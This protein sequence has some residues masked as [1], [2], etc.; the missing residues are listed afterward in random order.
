MD[1]SALTHGS[2]EGG[3]K[4]FLMLNLTFVGLNPI[5]PFHLLFPPFS[6]GGE[7]LE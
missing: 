2:V 6:E 1:A 5:L 7:E 4:L 3:G